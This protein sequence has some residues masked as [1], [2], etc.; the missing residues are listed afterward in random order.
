MKILAA[1][2][3]LVIALAAYLLAW[4]TGMEPV[5]WTPPPAPSITEGVYAY[6][7]KLKGIQKLARGVG[8]GPEGINVDA[9]GRVYAGYADGRIMTFAPDGSSWTELG[10]TRGRPLGITFGPD[11]GV[12]IADAKRGLLHLGRK[13]RTLAVAAEGVPF[14]FT[15]DV[16]NTRSDKN[17]YFT[18]ASSK[19]GYGRHMTDLLEHGANGRLLQYNVR[20]KETRMLMSGLHFANG[21]A[22]GPDDAYVLVNETAEY[23]ILRY[24][25]KGD[26]AGT[27]DVFVDNLPGLPDNLSY[28]DKGVFWV[29][30]FAPRDAMLDEL[31]PGNLYLR[32]VIAKLPKLLQPRPKP[33][34]FVLGL[35][36]EGKV[37]ANLQYAGAD[38]YAPITSVRQRGA[39]LYFGSLTYDA[40]GRL[41][42]N[43]AL[44]GAPAPPHGWENPPPGRAVPGLQTRE[45]R[46]EQLEE[47]RRRKGGEAEEDDEGDEAE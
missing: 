14:R 38:A 46:E 26:K 45:D 47:L 2:A 43:Q 10:N 44:A 19:F 5:A 36:L 12:V 1:L 23:R 15:D 30:L 4:P 34:A 31:L 42:L 18:D 40:I 29:A 6:N 8:V 32:T 41:P 3:V 20:T 17:V 21:V 33:H 16:D 11:G 28:N 24:W 39:F 9:V 13:L 7:E 35:D 22:V 25:L 27:H 37:V